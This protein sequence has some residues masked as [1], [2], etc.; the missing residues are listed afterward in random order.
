MCFLI[1]IVFPADASLTCRYMAVKLDAS[2]FRS[3]LA[4]KRLDGEECMAEMVTRCMS[5]LPL[6]SNFQVGNDS[7]K[8]Y[9]LD[10]VRDTGERFLHSIL[11]THTKAQTSSTKRS[12]KRSAKRSASSDQ[13]A[14]EESNAIIIELDDAPAAAYAFKLMKLDTIPLLH[15]DELID[16][17]QTLTFFN[18]WAMLEALA[19]AVKVQ[20]TI[21]LINVLA[22]SIEITHTSVLV[23]TLALGLDNRDF[24]VADC[25]HAWAILGD[26]VTPDLCTKMLTSSKCE[27][28]KWLWF[29][30]SALTPHDGCSAGSA[31]GLAR[32]CTL[33]FPWPDEHM[34]TFSNGCKDFF[35]NLSGLQVAFLQKACGKPWCACCSKVM[36]TMLTASRKRLDFQMIGC[37]DY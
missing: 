36:E 5:V 34:R 24:T 2:V 16:L 11:Q 35:A 18:A 6:R 17:I 25:V 21:S 10:L 1:F 28:A 22:A 37:F 23:T 31:T 14:S 4:S 15:V 26:V 13:T 7:F 20:N 12:T 33:D 32:P 3:T 29:T 30:L 9:T 8:V 27:A 19:A